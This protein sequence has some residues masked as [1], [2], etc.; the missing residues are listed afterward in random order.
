MYVFNVLV[1]NFL[2]LVVSGS[3]HIYLDAS[4]SFGSRLRPTPPYLQRV[5]VGRH[6]DL[7][8]HKKISAVYHLIHEFGEFCRRGRG[9]TGMG[10]G[11]CGVC[12]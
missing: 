6:G 9:E 5:A 7:P 12:R 4:P 8:P 3:M 1:N 10:I 2:K 11:I